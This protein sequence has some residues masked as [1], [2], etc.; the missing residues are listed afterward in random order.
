M[1]HVF[2]QYDRTSH[3][4][5]GIYRFCPMCKTELIF[6]TSVHRQSCPVC[7]FVHFRNPSPSVTVCIVQDGNV[8]LTKR[9][10]SPGK[11][12]W[13]IPGGYIEFEEDFLTTGIREMK[14]ETGLDV[15]IT[16][17][18]NIASSFISPRW[19]FLNVCLLAEV[20]GGELRNSD[21]IEAT[22][23]QPLTGQ[24]PDMAFPEDVENLRILS[25]PGFTGFPVHS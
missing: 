18:I 1:L 16:A 13:A 3:P 25:A 17:I 10:Y 9:A 20:V 11:N 12:M 19:H 14:E 4:T 15:Q 21:E 24:L 8:L 5:Q 6:D 2:E 7:G 23:W 22:H